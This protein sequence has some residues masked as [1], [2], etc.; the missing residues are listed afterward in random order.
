[1]YGSRSPSL[2][3]F[4]IG[5]IPERWDLAGEQTPVFGIPIDWFEERIERGELVVEGEHVVSQ[6]LASVVVKVGGASL[7]VVRNVRDRAG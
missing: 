4:V 1:M 7:E 2:V 5:I 3:P 6:L